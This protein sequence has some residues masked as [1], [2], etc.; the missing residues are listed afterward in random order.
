MVQLFGLKSLNGV[1]NL[2][3]AA[4][5]IN[6]NNLIKRRICTDLIFFALAAS[7]VEFLNI[8]K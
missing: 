3:S 7:S 1:I 4:N 8:L 5:N 2:G 6:T